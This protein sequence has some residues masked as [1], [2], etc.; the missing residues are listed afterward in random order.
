MAQMADNSEREDKLAAADQR[1]AEPAGAANDLRVVE[2]AVD[3]GVLEVPG[4]RVHE[5]VAKEPA[6]SKR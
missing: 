6:W 3:A 5:E 2:V 4:E 1:E